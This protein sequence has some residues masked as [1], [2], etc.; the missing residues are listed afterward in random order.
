MPVKAILGRLRCTAEEFRVL[1]QPLYQKPLP[2]T[3]ERL[4]AHSGEGLIGASVVPTVV[5][6]NGAQ[7]SGYV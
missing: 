3:L 4:L 5:L 7:R 6:D 1:V 2:V